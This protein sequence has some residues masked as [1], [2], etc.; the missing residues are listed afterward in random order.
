MNYKEYM[1]LMKTPFDEL[2]DEDQRKRTEEFNRRMNICKM[3]L[4]GM[5]Q[6]YINDDIDNLV[7]DDDP[8]KEMIEILK[9]RVN[10]IEGEA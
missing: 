3:F 9:V 1:K 5:M 4:V 10:E 8:M 7:P 6:G 2:T